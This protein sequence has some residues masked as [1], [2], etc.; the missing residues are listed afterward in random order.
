VPAEHFAYLQ[1]L[2]PTWRRELWV[3]M[4]AILQNAGEP[5]PS[6]GPISINIPRM[7]WLGEVGHKPLAGLISTDFV[8]L[9]VHYNL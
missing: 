4:I 2:G 6:A 5:K 9:A 1:Q 7:L 3:V 8:E